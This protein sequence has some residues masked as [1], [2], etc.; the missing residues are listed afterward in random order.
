MQKSI[1][2]LYLSPPS[3]ADRALRDNGLV[4]EIQYVIP[5]PEIN[6]WCWL[7]IVHQCCHL[8]V[9]CCYCRSPRLSKAIS[10]AADCRPHYMFRVPRELVRNEESWALPPED[11]VSIAESEL[12]LSPFCTCLLLGF[13]FPR[14]PHT[15]Q[16]IPSKVSGFVVGWYCRAL[17]NVHIPLTLPQQS[18][19]SFWLSWLRVS[20]RVEKSWSEE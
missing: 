19:A 2:L 18:W 1:L 7:S 11:A 20:W 4:G 5:F 3:P 8:E 17:G 10:K 13:W 12:Q 15:P 6:L 14:F 16:G 9:G